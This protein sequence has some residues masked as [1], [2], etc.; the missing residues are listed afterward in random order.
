MTWAAC[1]GLS[2][3]CMRHVIVKGAVCAFPINGGR[4]GGAA[5]LLNGAE[6]WSSRCPLPTITGWGE[7]A[8][9]VASVLHACHVALM[10][11]GWRMVEAGNRAATGSGGGSVPV[12]CAFRV[13]IG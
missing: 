12:P 13:L 7:V 4:R 5:H 2:S 11:L 3:A 9:P 6:V 1:V 10:R 8:S